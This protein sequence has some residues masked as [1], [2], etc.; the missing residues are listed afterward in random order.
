VSKQRATEIKVLPTYH[1]GVLFRSR[2]EARW[3]VFFDA[4][5]IPWVYEQE[6]FDL[7]NDGPYL[8]DFWLP[9]IEAF[10]EV[11]G[12]TPTEQEERLAARLATTTGKMV[13][14][15]FGPIGLAQQWDG[16]CKDCSCRV[17]N[18]SARAHF[19][20]TGG[21]SPYLWC[22]CPVCKKTGLNF[23]ARAAR[24]GCG[25]VPD[26]VHPDKWYQPHTEALHRAYIA[27]KRARFG[28]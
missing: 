15:A 12:A 21:D 24:L 8:P 27:A 14:I 2:L 13:Y 26:N 11:K 1:G 4:M 3:A 28:T 6:G 17:D 18:D 5:C 23:D 16:E 7:G 20:G 25:H 19:P 10:W 9:H 22:Q